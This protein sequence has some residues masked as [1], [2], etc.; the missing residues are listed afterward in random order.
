VLGG[1]FLSRL[2]HVSHTRSIPYS[3]GKMLFNKYFPIKFLQGI[4]LLIYSKREVVRV[5]RLDDTQLGH[6]ESSLNSREI[7]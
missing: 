3:I 6:N 2:R 5:T 1:V 7:E 4:V